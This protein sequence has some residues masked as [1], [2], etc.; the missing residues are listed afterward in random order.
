MRVSVDKITGFVPKG[1]NPVEMGQTRR[2]IP[3]P[4]DDRI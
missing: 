4:S 3:P 1:M 2:Q